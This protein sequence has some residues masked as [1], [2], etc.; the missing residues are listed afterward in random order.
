[1]RDGRIA[2][3]VSAESYNGWRETC[4]QHGITV[5]AM[6][7]VMGLQMSERVIKGGHDFD[8]RRSF[9]AFLQRCRDVDA[10]RRRRNQHG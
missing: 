7:E 3:N 8:S 6:L 5:T 10:E 4:R 9:D 1:M 2:G